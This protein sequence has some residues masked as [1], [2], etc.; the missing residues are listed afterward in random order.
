M[1]TLH[2]S[3][4]FNLVVDNKAVLLLESKHTK[5]LLVCSETDGV[6]KD[7]IMFN[8]LD[9]F[10]NFVMANCGHADNETSVQIVHD[11][12]CAVQNGDYNGAI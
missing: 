9:H 7:C 11:L 8:D 2:K 6:I 10:Q 4:L 1:A 3:Y 12:I 5:A